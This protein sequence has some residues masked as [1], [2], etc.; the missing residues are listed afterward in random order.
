MI[1]APTAA[2]VPPGVAARG[3]R[4]PSK[5]AR[6][7]LLLRLRMSKFRSRSKMSGRM[8]ESKL[9]R[10]GSKKRAAPAEAEAGCEVGGLSTDG[11]AST[12]LGLVDGVGGRQAW[13]AFA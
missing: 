7:M 6:L 1:D 13:G 12:S 11:G 9:G 5:L 10:E 8:L 2:A 4:I 3:V